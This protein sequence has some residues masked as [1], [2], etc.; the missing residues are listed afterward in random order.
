VEGGVG[1]VV[2]VRST[3]S[4]RTVVFVDPSARAL[5][6]RAGMP[7]TEAR[8]WCASVRADE[9][10]PAGDA[11]ALAALARWATRFSPVV[12]PEYPD[13][14]IVDLTGT[15]RCLG[16]SATVMKRAYELLLRMGLTARLAVAPTSAA[17]W[18]IASAGGGTGSGVVVRDQALPTFL[19]ALPVWALRVGED[20]VERLRRLGVVRIGQLRRLP[21]EQLPARFGEELTARLDAAFGRRAEVLVTPSLPGKL[22]ERIEFDSGGEEGGGGG[23]VVVAPEVVLEALELLAGKLCEELRR[24][25]R[26]ARK[27][28]VLFERPYLPAI[29]REVRLASASRQARRWMDL[30]VHIA[31]STPHDDGFTAITIKVEQD[32][33]LQD[34]QTHFPGLSVAG[35]GAHDRDWELLVESLTARLGPGTLL[36]PRAVRSYIPERSVTLEDC[37]EARG[38]RAERSGARMD[39]PGAGMNLPDTRM[40]L[41]DMR[42]DLPVRMFAAPREVRVMV[43]PHEDREGRPIAVWWKG[44]EFRITHAAGPRRIA[45]E[46]WRGHDKTRDYFDAETEQGRRL[47]LFRVVESGRWWWQGEY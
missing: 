24:R 28:C 34:E 10:D 32:E 41:P 33:P 13:A 3:P 44:R 39:L 43:S 37:A 17:A 4:R 11:M 20:I 1:G 7:L 47:C 26:G 38:K 19:D 18:A 8:A 40:E 45:G 12:V 21:R 27:L 6:I 2:L 42:M 46:W 31:E 22:L 23:G 35:V 9:H 36:R 14:L 5:G 30:L 29:E 16:P 25:E 15:E